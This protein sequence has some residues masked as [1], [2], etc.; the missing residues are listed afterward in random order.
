MHGSTRRCA[1]LERE[2]KE[3]FPGELGQLADHP[4]FD[5]DC[6]SYYCFTS[7][8]CIVRA[9]APG[10]AMTKR[11][12]GE[13]QSWSASGELLGRRWDGGGPG[14]GTEGQRTGRAAHPEAG[15]ARPGHRHGPGTFRKP[16]WTPLMITLTTEQDRYDGGKCRDWMAE[17]K[18]LKGRQRRQSQPNPCQG[19]S[20]R[21][22]AGASWS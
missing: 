15:L 17:G 2:M 3:W 1:M 21:T 7:L 20:G 9:C 11:H 12:D 16:A 19:R 18:R 13:E 6:A 10:R 8:V 4:T 14:V 22:R 5:S